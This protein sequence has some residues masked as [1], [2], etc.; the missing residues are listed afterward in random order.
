MKC[1]QKQKNGSIKVTH[2]LI[3]NQPDEWDQLATIYDKDGEY[4]RN[5][6]DSKLQNPFA[7]QKS[8]HFSEEPTE[9]NDSDG[10]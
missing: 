10:M 1:T 5:Y 4:K 3:D 2:Y 6:L 9:S 8:S 7:D